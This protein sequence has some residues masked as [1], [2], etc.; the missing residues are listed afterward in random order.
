MHIYIHMKNTHLFTCIYTYIHA[1][2]KKNF[3][4]AR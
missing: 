2:T 4:S 1:Y 3:E